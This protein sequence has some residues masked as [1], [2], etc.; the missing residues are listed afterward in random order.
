VVADF[1]RISGKFQKKVVF[2]L[3]EVHV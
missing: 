1:L 3:I 2:I